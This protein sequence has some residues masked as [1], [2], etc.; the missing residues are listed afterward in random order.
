MAALEKPIQTASTA[1]NYDQKKD[2]SIISD[3]DSWRVI[4]ATHRTANDFSGKRKSDDSNCP[5]AN[6][7][8]TNGHA[9]FWGWQSYCNFHTG[10]NNASGKPNLNA[11]A[12]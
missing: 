5:P 8:A 10:F 11:A 1:I 4:F 3:S 12:G 6:V 2:F 9:I 7:A